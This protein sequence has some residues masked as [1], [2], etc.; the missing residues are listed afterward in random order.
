M[1]RALGQT[2]LSVSPIGLGTVKLGRTRKLR[3][4]EPFALPTEEEAAAVLHGALDAGVNLID[5]AAAY[6]LAEERI[7]RHLADR[8]DEFVLSTKAGEVFDEA[9][10]RSRFDFTAAGLTASLER[11]LRALRTDRV[12]ALLLHSDGRDLDVMHDDAV[13]RLLDFKRQGKA[14]CVG[15]S[16]KTV[17][18]AEAALKWA[19]LLMVAFHADDESHRA[20]IREADARGV[21]VIVK[22]G[23]ASGRHDASAAVRFLMG[24]PAVHAAVVGTRSLEHLRA[25]VAVAEACL[26]PSAVSDPADAD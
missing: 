13:G 8:R 11:S 22:K 4:A 25:N 6:G 19:D 26:N 24:E 20:V 14:R 10:D 16:S 15:V 1:R 12:E 2:G 21:G 3:Y 17:A 18:G 23:L 5:T 9:A 7:G